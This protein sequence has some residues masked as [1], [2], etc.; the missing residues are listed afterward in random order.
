M[1]IIFFPFKFT[2]QNDILCQH[3]Q[4][5]NSE[6]INKKMASS[7]QAANAYLASTSRAS[8]SLNSTEDKNLENMM[9]T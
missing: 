5:K 7:A 1:D 9:E 6:W 2:T 3:Y 4:I 8:S